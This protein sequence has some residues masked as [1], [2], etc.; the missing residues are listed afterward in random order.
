MNTQKKVLIADDDRIFTH[1]V[2]ANL[3]SRGW[4][5]EVANDAMQAFMF[6]V[7]NQPTAIVL[8]IHMP[9]GNGLDVLQRLRLSSRTQQIPVVIVSGS[10]DRDET[11]Q[12]RSL[13]AI[14]FLQ[15]PADPTV[16]RAILESV[17]N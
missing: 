14:G 9:G 3:R 4:E 8:D 13:G 6:A 1:L 12:V 11:D 16:L 5:V 15:K 17:V 10:S 2:S 7:R